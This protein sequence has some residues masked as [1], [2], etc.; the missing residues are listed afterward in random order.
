[1]S[2]TVTDPKS[3]T[4]NADRSMAFLAFVAIVFLGYIILR[5][6]SLKHAVLFM[7]GTGLGMALLHASF[8]FSGGWRNF[9]RDGDSRAVRAHILLLALASAMAIPILAG[10]FPSLHA[11][12]AMG[13]VG[14][15]VIVGSFLFGIG[16]QLGGGCGSGTLYTVGGGHVRMLITLSFFIIGATLGSLHLGWWLQMPSLGKISLITEL[17]WPVALVAQFALLGLLFFIA[18]AIESR[19]RQ[20]IMKIFDDEALGITRHRLLYGPWPILWGVVALAIFGLLTLIIAGY[21]WS[22][23][24]AFGLW[25]A[26]IWTALGGDLSN[27]AFWSGG[28]PEKAL[29]RTVLADITSVMDFG[30]ILGAVLAASLANRFAP[31]GEFNIGNI[32]TA[33]IGG[34]LLGYGARLAF[35]CNIG[36][37]LGGIS[38]A[39]VHGWLWLV[40]AFMGNIVGTHLRV[41]FGIDEPIGS[42]G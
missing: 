12:P 9:I 40:F 3:G 8:G 16:M 21:P 42:S 1:M 11:S 28:Y 30:I 25:G 31:E 32:M 36:A 37:L 22:I 27:W 26:K 13:P 39:S 33:I 5:D 34:L 38:S 6:I 19:S 7:I 15:S 10:V 2:Q 23:T 17:G 4:A 18:S 29:G 14:I 41:M 35:G 24:F 20:P